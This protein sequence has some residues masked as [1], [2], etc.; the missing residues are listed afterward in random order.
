MLTTLVLAAS[1]VSAELRWQ[2]PKLLIE[3]PEIRRVTFMSAVTLPRRLPQQE[4]PVE[5]LTMSYVMGLAGMPTTSWWAF[6]LEDGSL[7]IE[8]RWRLAPY[9]NT[10]TLDPEGETQMWY[11]MYLV[12][13]QQKLLLLR[14]PFGRQLARFIV[15]R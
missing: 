4:I 3:V 14:E 13:Q 6:Q 12:R 7:H 1:I 5:N 15:D 8:M 2:V 9:H 11:P 10:L